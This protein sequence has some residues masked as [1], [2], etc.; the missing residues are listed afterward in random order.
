M[1]KQGR[2]LLLQ[3][4]KTKLYIAQKLREL[5]AVSRHAA[6]VSSFLH[7]LQLYTFDQLTLLH[8]NRQ[9]F[10]HAPS[11]FSKVGVLMTHTLRL[12]RVLLIKISKLSRITYQ[13][14]WSGREINFKSNW[15]SQQRFNPLVVEY[16]GEKKSGPIFI[17][18]PAQVVPLWSAVTLPLQSFYCPWRNNTFWWP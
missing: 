1:P 18:L 4:P 15:H 6:I 5:L 16:S 12:L 2:A 10:D 7:L 11:D 8:K 17:T 13:R 9:F 14:K 3:T